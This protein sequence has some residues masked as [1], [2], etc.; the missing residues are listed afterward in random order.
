MLPGVGE[1]RL[2]ALQK[3]GISSVRD[4]AF[5]LPGAY[6]D[7]TVTTAVCMLETGMHTVFFAALK[8]PPSILR[9]GRLSL[10]TCVFADDTGE[11]SAM[12]F[13]RPYL[14]Q[15]LKVGQ[16]YAVFAR[17]EA[18]RGRLCAQNPTFVA[19]DELGTIQPVYPQI[20]GIPAKTY[21]RL[22]RMALEKI[23]AE[24]LLPSDLRQE[25]HLITRTQALLQA[26][27][28]VDTAK[29]RQ[30]QRYWA[31]ENMLLYQLH[32]RAWKR[33]DHA[34]VRIDAGG[35]MAAFF[36][37]LPFEPTGAQK[38]VID[39]IL[40]DLAAPDAMAR[41]VQGDVGSGKTAVAQ[42]ALF[43][44]V[45]GGYQGA[46]MA[47]TEVLAR[48]HYESCQKLLAP[49]G[50]TVGLLVGSMT[51]KQH[52]LA[53]EAIASGMWQV[54]VGT[55]A[56][57]TE[58]VVYQNLG[59]AIT[60]EQHRFG[61]RQRTELGD[62]GSGVNVL[63][64][65]ATPIPRT[66]TLTLYGDLAVSVLDELP[67]GRTPVKTH[68]VPEHKRSGMYGFLAQQ[69]REGRQGY[70]VCPLIEKNDALGLLSAQE[71]F[72]SLKAALPELRIALVHGA[73][74][75]AAK[76]EVLGAFYAGK[77]DILVSTTVIEVGVNVPNASFMV[78]EEAHRFGLAQL[79][80]LRGRVGRGNW[81]SYCFLMA[82]GGQKLRILTKTN[83]GFVIAQKDLEL[84][85]PGDLA[86]T[87][88]SGLAG[89]TAGE[90]LA[91]LEAARQAAQLCESR[92]QEPAYQR[93]WEAA[94]Q[95]GQA[96]G[97]VN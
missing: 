81:E 91:L 56:L 68:L 46:L 18:F 72:E 25:N 31:F 76:E 88:Q 41:M 6:R 97:G 84:R 57:I 30:A 55:H 34:G 51:A 5:R 63:V 92:A 43:A 50:V 32:L 28:P 21:R 33:K 80:Q 70:V 95:F 20:E 39:E 3:A 47:P 40:S 24:E 58:Q 10:T 4:L 8:K 64:M 23:A 69:A 14:R 65:S 67:P 22:V 15:T 71:A 74:K 12:F 53:H 29:L 75:Q 17:I 89:E 94:S 82:D 85:G 78:V 86:G 73:M 26:H 9:S 36:A 7:Y 27:F 66:L 2:Q 79:H 93:L 37:A 11:I 59:L 48:Q 52:R 54:V 62:K 13:N 16:K 1:K 60:D 90:D 38:R 42:A 96:A 35:Q 77:L 19:S 87:R 83:D 44:C 61:V 45:K 49:L